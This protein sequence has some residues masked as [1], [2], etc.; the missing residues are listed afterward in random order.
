MQ[1]C[2]RL[3]FR[4]F[5]GWVLVL[6]ALAVTSGA[7]TPGDAVIVLRVDGAIGPATADYIHRGLKRAAEAGSGLLVIEMDTPGG[8]DTS[9]RA[10]IKDI[11]ASS[12]PVATFVAPEG[13]RAASA[14][15]YILYA[16]HIAAMAPATNL[17][18]ATPVAIG[19]GGSQPDTPDTS[20][21]RRPTD[22]ADSG[23]SPQPLPEPHKE[24]KRSSDEQ[25][26][27]AK[28]G[29]GDAMTT[30]SVEDATAYIRSLAQLRG[31]NVEFAV[32][33]VREAASLSSAE[34]LAQ[35]VIDLV[36]VDLPDLL[37]QLEGREVAVMGGKVVLATARASVERFDPDWR[38]RILA[39]LATP[40]V[41]LILMMIGIYGLFFEFSSPGAVVPGVA[42]AISLLI[43]L[44]AFQLLPVNWAGVLL[45]AIGAIMMLAEAFIPSFGALGVGGIIAFIV[46]G[47]F[48]MDTEVPGFGVP[49][50][51]I[52]GLAFA[53][54]A[55]LLAIGSFAARSARRPV[56]SGR[57]VM[58][59]AA[60]T[61]I[62]QTDD[63]QWWV[64][65][66]GE[67][68]QARSETPLKPG[69]RVRVEG[70]DGLTVDV[71]PMSDSST[72]RRTP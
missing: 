16:S 51:L 61:V 6:I 26:P 15:T 48:L 7:A 40:Q 52:I 54:A 1:V 57:E 21:G 22:A 27:P 28:A 25:Q 8:L 67:R 43:A 69:D 33:A 66:R 9:M 59:G 58:T 38:N 11:L 63:G 56:V 62:G 44:Y 29:G 20:T 23:K 14:G 50:P 68:W 37:A 35:N 12:V 34:A 5:A 2:S 65:V 10:I 60:G 64:L 30:K 53:S 4:R 72:S 42:G 32:R 47:I 24:G 46:G 18:A 71:T 49:L 45:L 17:G 41:A 39:V 13:A 36:A 70:L 3:W 19:I 55:L 31:R